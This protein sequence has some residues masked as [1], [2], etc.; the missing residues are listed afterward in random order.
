MRKLGILGVISALVLLV[1]QIAVAENVSGADV[2]ICSGVEATVCSIELGCEI[3]APWLW[4][5]PEF[6]EIDL[7]AKKVSTTA[8]SGANRETPITSLVRSDGRIFLQGVERGRAF[9]F[10]IGEETGLLTAAVARDEITV[11]VFGACTPLSK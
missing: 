6:V 8:A 7:K 4:G 9:S 10:V 3:G 1:P 11:S 2:M 5:I